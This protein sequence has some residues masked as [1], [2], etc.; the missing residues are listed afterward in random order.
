M[1]DGILYVVATP[2]GNL[3]DFTQRAIDVLKSVELIACEDTRV[4]QKL[5]NYFGIGTKTISYHKFSEKERSL[6][7]LE[8]LKSGQN[9]ALVSD[10]GTPLISDPG[11]I[12]VQE[13]QKSGLKIVPIP[14]CCAAITALSAI[15]NDG[16]FAFWGFF[17]QKEAEI[18]NLQKFLPDFNLVFY[19][20]PNRILK[21]L[22]SIKKIFG[23]VKISIARELT[24]IHEDINTKS[25]SQMIDY[26]ETSVVKGEIVFIVHKKKKTEENFDFSQQARKLAKLGYSTKDISRILAA[27]FELPKNEIYKE[28][29]K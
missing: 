23:E 28:L 16:S 7:I 12:L 26:L 27:I 2:I 25:I 13:V 11:S 21:T 5:L 22:Y 8:L 19:E 6:R 10:A 14:G 1:S 15:P 17:P 4:T 20:S 24:K 9:I 29:N 18:E 3:A